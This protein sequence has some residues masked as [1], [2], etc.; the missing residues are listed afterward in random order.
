MTYRI[1]VAGA[2]R[3]DLKRLDR[4]V[5]RAVNEAIDALACDPRPPGSR[6]WSASPVGDGSGLLRPPDRAD[7]RRVLTGGRIHPGRDRQLHQPGHRSLIVPV[8]TI[9]GHSRHWRMVAPASGTS[10]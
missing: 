9:R 6:S 10:I 4:P 1:V 8:V 3:R 2:A 5:A 7:D